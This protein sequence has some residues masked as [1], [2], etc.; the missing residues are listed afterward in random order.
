MKNIKRSKTNEKMG[1]D[2]KTNAKKTKLYDKILDIALKRS[3]IMPSAEIY[4]PVAGFYD[5]GPIGTLMKSK[6]EQYWRKMFIKE[7]G[8]HEIETA[9]IYP[10]IVFRGSGHARHFADPLTTCKKCGRKFS[11]DKLVHDKTGKN[12]DTMGEPELTRIISEYKIKCPECNGMLTDVAKFAL[13]FK[14]T[15]AGDSKNIAYLR[16]ETAQGIFLDFPRI[17][18]TYGS[19][20]PLGIAQVG[21]AFRNEISPRRILIRL[22]EFGQ[23][24]VE[25]FY[26]P[27]AD[28]SIKGYDKVKNLKIRFEDHD[29]TLA[30]AV[31]NNYV[32][33]EIHAYFVGLVK[34][35]YDKMGVKKYRF[36]KLGDNE[37]AHYAKYAVDMEVETS[38]GWTEVVSIADRG[39][40]DLSS[41]SKLSN[42]KLNVY[43]ERTGE[44]V[45]PYVIE[46]SFG[47]SR[48]FWC[49]LE[50]SYRPADDKK[51]WEW[52]DLPIYISPYHAAVYPLVKKEALTKTAQKILSQL[53]G[54]GL[55]IIYKESGSI[56]KRYARAD[57]IGVAYAIT[58]DFQT[59]EDNT[60]T[61]RFR[62]DSKQVRVMI[63][64]LYE[65]II[66]YTEKDVRILKDAQKIKTYPIQNPAGA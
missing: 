6:I 48:L 13:M 36:R 18:S 4:N 47:F 43:D 65:T 2:T 15:Y 63:D 8:F 26:N 54:K 46:P 59:I 53:R 39:D 58:I 24:E 17:F 49:I 27:K 7:P 38:F 10:E 57:E 28:K 56:G 42:K 19:K 55:D 51:K 5:Y 64:E 52:F 29:I 14:T 9:V 37:K 60:V 61:L 22:R 31:K 30:D 23:M 1:K 20:L 40:Y 32:S 44:K 35:F 62:N 3:I 33:N 50:A 45:I 16:P 34:Q 11:A 25:Y 66:L 21:K 41:H 12:C